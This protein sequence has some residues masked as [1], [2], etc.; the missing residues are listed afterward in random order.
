LIGINAS[1]PAWFKCCN[2]GEML[3]A[4]LCTA[5]TQGFPSTLDLFR[6]LEEVRHKV[7]EA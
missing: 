2:F 7:A 6:K 4:D 3:G 5:I 1:P